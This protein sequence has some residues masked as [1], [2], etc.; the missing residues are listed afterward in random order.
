MNQSITAVIFDMDGV[1]VDTNPTHLLAYRQF[2]AKRNIYPSDQEFADYMFGKSNRF[3]LEH[4]FQ[5]AIS[6]EEFVAYENEKEGLFRELYSPIATPIIGFMTFLE[7]LKAAGIKTGIG[8]SAPRANLDLILSKIPLANKME[9]LLSSE[10]V[11]KHKPNPEVYLKS[12]Q[13]LDIDI[14]NCVIFEDSFS[15]VMAAKNAGAKVVGVL[16]THTEAE[17]PPCDFYIKN[18]ENLTVS[19][20]LALF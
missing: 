20:I 8:T 5:K 7:G 16:S 17:L 15:G 2:M 3:I 10:N 9:S 4:F 11:I 6:Q 1:I 14:A 12:A 18:Y 13:N 19:S